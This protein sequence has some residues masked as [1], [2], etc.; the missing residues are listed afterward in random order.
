MKDTQRTEP[1]APLLHN[2]GVPPR[3]VIAY[4]GLAG[5]ART[6]GPGGS[7][8][9]GVSF[10]KQQPPRIY[11]TPIRFRLE[12]QAQARDAAEFLGR[13]RGTWTEDEGQNDG[14][15]LPDALDQPSSPEKVLIT[16]INRQARGLPL[17]DGCLVIPAQDHH[18]LWSTDPLT[19]LAIF[20]K[21]TRSVW[22]R[23][24]HPTIA[25]GLQLREVSLLLPPNYVVTP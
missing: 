19:V 22:L 3:T 10:G 17:P 20:S 2:S 11:G 14:E 6:L 8:M 7:G 23:A 13:L 9:A 25:A 24:K 12:P 16:L 18:R 5:M 4:E 1:R 21:S 15:E